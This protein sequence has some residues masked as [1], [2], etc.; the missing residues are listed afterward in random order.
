LIDTSADFYG[1]GWMLIS[2]QIWIYFL[3]LFVD[4]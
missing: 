4:L 1:E 3:L 2:L